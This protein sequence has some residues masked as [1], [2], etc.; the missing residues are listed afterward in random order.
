[1]ED[2]FD[3]DRSSSGKCSILNLALVGAI[4]DKETKDY[5]AKKLRSMRK[6]VSKFNKK[7]WGDRQCGKMTRETKK[8]G[9]NGAGTTQTTWLTSTRTTD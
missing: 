9:N 2:L 5:L 3:D 8:N 7:N 1:M 6:K 4:M